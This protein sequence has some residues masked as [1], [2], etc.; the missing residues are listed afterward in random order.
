[1]PHVGVLMERSLQEQSLKD[2]FVNLLARSVVAAVD[3]RQSVSSIQG[4]VE[5]AATAFSSWDN[6]MQAAFCKYA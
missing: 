1:M 2:A 5:D 6:C 3:K 4:S